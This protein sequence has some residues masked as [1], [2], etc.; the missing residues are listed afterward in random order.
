MMLLDQL[1]ADL[2]VLGTVTVDWK[3]LAEFHFP[4]RNGKVQAQ[5]WALKRGFVLIFIHPGGQ[6][7]EDQAIKATFYRSALRQPT[8]S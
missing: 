4:G 2:K 3:S 1:I 5:K 8:S 7:R 6:E